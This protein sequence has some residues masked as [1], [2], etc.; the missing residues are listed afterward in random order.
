MCPRLRSR[1]AAHRLSNRRPQQGRGRTYAL[2]N[3]ST[4]VRFYVV[5]KLLDL[6][7]DP[8]LC[9]QDL[10]TFDVQETKGVDI[11]EGI[12]E[13]RL[14]EGLFGIILRPL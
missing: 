3:T 4:R 9:L 2:D 7:F 14:C 5:H 11:T 10:T 8:S 1:T 13:L 6:G 12:E